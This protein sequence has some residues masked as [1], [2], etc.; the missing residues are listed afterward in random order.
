MLSHY[1][2]NIFQWMLLFVLHL[3]LQLV[4]VKLVWVLGTPIVP[5]IKCIIV[6]M[7]V[8]LC[9]LRVGNIQP[10]SIPKNTGPLLNYIVVGSDNIMLLVVLEVMVVLGPPNFPPIKL[11]LVQTGMV[12]G[13]EH[14]IFIAHH[15][16][17]YHLAVLII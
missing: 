4:M 1:G 2:V 12:G 13:F 3:V 17:C 10:W 16:I 6:F 15:Y 14:I 9:H 8:I 7:V 5:P 11:I